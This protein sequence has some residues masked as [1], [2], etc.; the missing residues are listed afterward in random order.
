MVGDGTDP[1]HPAEPGGPVPRS[2]SEIRQA[3]RAQPS[4]IEAILEV[5]A[6]LIP[7]I[8]EAGYQGRA[9]ALVEEARLAVAAIE[10]SPQPGIGRALAP[11][12]RLDGMLD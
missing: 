1:G 3:G 5:L 8:T 6:D 4:L 12:R 2:F 11:A 9:Q 10:G 7:E